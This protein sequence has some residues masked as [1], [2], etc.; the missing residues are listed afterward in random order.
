MWG[1]QAAWS[2]QRKEGE[3]QAQEVK[4]M[5]PLCASS[6]AWNFSFLSHASSSPSCE[7]GTITLTVGEKTACLRSHSRRDKSRSACCPGPTWSLP[8]SP[9]PTVLGRPP[10]PPA[11][12]E[13]VRHVPVLLHLHTRNL[14]HQGDDLLSLLQAL[15]VLHCGHFAL[16]D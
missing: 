10:G 16:F 7:V 3:G 15:P 6:L 5:R 13:P 11:S 4:M 12:P 1:P 8:L 9:F 14:R 2:V